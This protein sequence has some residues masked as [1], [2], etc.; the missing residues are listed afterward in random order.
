VV[1]PGNRPECHDNWTFHGQRFFER[2]RN[3]I[4]SLPGH[5][6]VLE[7]ARVGGRLEQQRRDM[8]GLLLGINRSI[9]GT[10]LSS[11]NSSVSLGLVQGPAWV[12]GQVR[13]KELGAL[14]NGHTKVV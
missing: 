13:L 1:I 2:G 7:A 5:N 12:P 4:G 8:N 9:L 10:V 3:L 14:G 11:F 6:A